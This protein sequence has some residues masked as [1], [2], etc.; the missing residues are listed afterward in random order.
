MVKLI[1]TADWH[2][3]C[4]LDTLERR[5][6]HLLFLE[7]LLKRLKQGD[8]DGLLISGD[9]FDSA[10][11]PLSAQKDLFNFLLEARR[12]CRTI[13][14]TAGN[15]DSAVR[16][17]T[18]AT[19]LRPLQIHCLGSM[20]ESRETALIPVGDSHGET[21]ACI[22][23]IPFLRGTDLPPPAPGETADAAA[24]HMIDSV[25][26]LMRGMAALH[27]GKHGD[28]I[29]LVYMAHMFVHGGRPT[30][31]SERPVQTIAGNVFSLP[32]EIFP[33]TAA[34][35]ALGH[36]HRCQ[37]IKHPADVPMHY[38]GSV[39]PMSFTEAG[40]RHCFMEVDISDASTGAREISVTQHAIP[41]G[42][43]MEEVT[44]DED[45]V[46]GNLQALAA[47]HPDPDD[48]VLVRVLVELTGP[49]PALRRRLEDITA[50]TGVRIMAMRRMD[51]ETDTMHRLL[52]D[53]QR[54][55]DLS[56]EDVFRLL[57]RME[58]S[59]EP[60]GA[61]MA[62]FRELLHEVTAGDNGVE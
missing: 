38:S 25:T 58:Y 37:R 27:R 5:E 28:N 36:L 30:E 2:L 57:H 50:G 6:E 11:P 13:I 61:L 46:T 31:D 56:P 9:I 18:L 44:G 60:D 1:H 26:D 52:E 45:R 12:H 17:D 39:I 32:P 40:Y 41:R 22:A 62:A 8:V 54:L 24:T 14:M 23:A 53:N 49:A 15:H 7:S 34:Y 21:I 33:D 51:F 55:D 10:N 42:L 29:P 3:G 20:P 35:V 16:L 4:R 19:L 47:E 48:T 59:T 43:I